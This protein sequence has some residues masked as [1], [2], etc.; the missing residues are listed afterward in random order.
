MRTTSV[1]APSVSAETIAAVSRFAGLAELCRQRRGRRG[2]LDLDVLD[3]LAAEQL[4]IVGRERG[5]QRLQ[6]MHEQRALAQRIELRQL[7]VDDFEVIDAV[8]RRAAPRPDRA[9]S[10][11]SKR[12]S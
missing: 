5:R 6:A 4:Q 3:A 8:E 7:A 12:R 11:R 1:L 9:A 10:C 2:P